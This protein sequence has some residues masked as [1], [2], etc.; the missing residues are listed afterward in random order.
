MNIKGHTTGTLA[1]VASMVGIAFS[2]LL[3]KLAMGAGLHP[4]WLNVLRVG[5]SVVILLPFFLS[6]REARGA[7]FRLRRR[8]KAITLLA[9]LMLAIHFVAWATALSL[10]DS[11]IA[12]TIWSTFSLMTV[13]GSALLLKERTPPPALLGI[14][15][16]ILGVAIC[17]VG[18]GPSQRMGIVMALIAAVT[19]AV[20]TLC[21]RAVR[22]NLA[23]LPYTTVVYSVALGCVVACVLAMRI[24]P[25][26][27][28]ARG[29]GAAVALALICTLGGHSM[30]NHALK[31]YK[32][33]TVSAAILTEVFTGPLLVF[34]FMGEAPKLASVLGGIVIMLGVG[35]YMI[36]EWRHTN[37]A[38]PGDGGQKEHPKVPARSGAGGGD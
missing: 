10:A 27:M 22:R 15:V 30:Q 32:A 38:L 23:T 34:V 20:Y 17:A 5:V 19:Q 35:W 21:G 36:Y 31:Y 3:N 1:L 6:N 11:V 25:A 4:I 12:V 29:I 9:G 7:F 18:A 33:P 26:G 14:V 28:N 13:I 2:A 16:A 37:G 8:D 24:P